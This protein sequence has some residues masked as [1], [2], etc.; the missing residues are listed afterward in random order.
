MVPQVVEP[1]FPLCSM[2]ETV[3]KIKLVIHKDNDFTLTS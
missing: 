3:V 1:L 2:L